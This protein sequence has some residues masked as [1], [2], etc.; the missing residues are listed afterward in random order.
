MLNRRS[1]LRRTAS[2]SAGLALSQPMRG[3]GSAIA[4]ISIRLKHASPLAQIPANFIGLGYEKS[5]AAKTGLL[6]V[7]NS[8]YVQLLSNFG[9]SGV[10]RIGGIVADFSRYDPEGRSAAEPKNTVITRAMLEQLSGF[11]KKTGWTA[12]WCLNFGQGSLA[13]ALREVKDV[14]SALGSHLDSIELGNEVENYGRGVKPLRAPPYT[15][16]AYRT[17]YDE[18]HKAIAKA[19]PGIRFAAP[20]TAASVEWLEQMA[21]DANGEVQLLTTHYYRGGQQHGSAEQLNYP[22]PNLKT[23]LER[24]ARAS[25]ESGIPWRMCETNS[26][27]GGGLPGVSDTMLGALWTLDYMLLLAQN[28][29]AGVNIETGVNQLGFVSSY[30]PIQDDGESNNTAG[31]PYYGMLA[32]VAAVTGSPQ[33]LP[34]DFDPQGINL[35]CYVCGA[36]GKPRAVV[37][38]NR[39]RSQD[40]YLSVAELGMGELTGYRLTAPAPESRNGVTFGGMAVNAEGKWTPTRAEHF[41]DALVAVPRM[42]AVVLRFQLPG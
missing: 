3:W 41:H 27:S 36:G 12:I 10:L 26:F 8:R 18:W 5:S 7:T 31:A 23:K 42:S 9:G 1:F 33:V 29:C 6:S 13:E 32:F 4:P 37:V 14:A 15:Y 21:K 16:E 25:Q 2:I 22:D 11:L 40:A 17:E 24:L 19:V 28:G 30:S 39:E 38:V 20:D 34:I 35:T